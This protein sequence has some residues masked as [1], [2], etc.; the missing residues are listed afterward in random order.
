MNICEAD[1][2]DCA[3]LVV[4]ATGKLLYLYYHL[5]YLEIIPSSRH[6][7]RQPSQHLDI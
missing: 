3:V 7:Q 6:H 1:C 5:Y 2:D 4:S